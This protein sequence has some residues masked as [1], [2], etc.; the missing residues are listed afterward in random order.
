MRELRGIRKFLYLTAVVLSAAAVNVVYSQRLPLRLFTSAD[1]MASSVIHQMARDS[2]GFIWFCARGGLSR[3]DGNQFVK[4]RITPDQPA[5]LVHYFTETR[6][7]SYWVSTEAGLFRVRPED[8]EN[9]EPSSEILPPGERSLNAQ[10]VSSTVF[11][12]MFEDAAGRFWAGS[13]DLYLLR[14]L[15]SEKVSVTKVPFKLNP[16]REN[17]VTQRSIVDGRDG[18]VWFVY[19]SGV[20]R[21]FPDRQFVN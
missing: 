8:V 16:T 5:P 17:L 9:V 11:W 14:D 13:D 3:W 12:V 4:Y 21:R 1:G 19:S 20:A 7:G 2:K 10:K 18:E 6:D 15:N